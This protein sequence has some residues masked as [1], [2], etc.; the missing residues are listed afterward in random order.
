MHVLKKNFRKKKKNRHSYLAKGPINH[1]D[2]EKVF[3]HATSNHSTVPDKYGISK[4][5][6]SFTLLSNV[7]HF[8]I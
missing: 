1:Y 7:Y 5:K 3:W 4:T 6:S 2:I 8:S